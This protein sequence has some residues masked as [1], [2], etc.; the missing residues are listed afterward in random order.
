[1][2]ETTAQEPTMEEILA[3]IRRIISEDEAPA[4]ANAE[5]AAAPLHAVDAPT[6]F[7]EPED[8]EVLE[9]DQP[10]QAD[11]ESA[12]EPVEATAAFGDIEARPA[13]EPV[14]EAEVLASFDAPKPRLVDDVTAQ[15][16]AS[17]FANL[18]ANIAMPREGRTLEDL[19]KE[20]MYP[21]LKEWL[22]QNLPSIVEAEVRAEVDRLSRLRGAR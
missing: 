12:P 21:L 18:G 16:V 7:S 10:Y 15:S 13:P 5:A 2:S 4:G 20:M 1:M 17:A 6:A 19:V 14:F 11:F 22:N 9:L 3:S 8:E